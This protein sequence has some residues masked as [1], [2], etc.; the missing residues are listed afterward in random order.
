MLETN[1]YD[2]LTWEEINEAVENNPVALIP[3][4][5]VEDHGKHLPLNTDRFLASKICEGTAEKMGDKVLLLPPVTQ[6]F[7][8]H[9]MEF[10]GGITIGWSNF[11]NHLV[12]ITS[13]LAHHGFQKILMVNGHGS[14]RP[15]VEIAARLTVVQNS[16]VHC[17]MLSWWDIE[18]VQETFSEVIESELCSHGAECETSLY[19]ALNPEGVKMERAEKDMSFP[20]SDYIYP[21]FYHKEKKGTSVKSMEW[22]STRSRTGVIGDPTKASAEKGEKIYKSAVEGLSKIVTDLRDREFPKREDKHRNR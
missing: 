8:P 4:G 3:V 5:S 12:D 18:E 6:G 15:L 2:E 7:L 9:H 13:S 21:G 20:E 17:A 16:K 1:I 19:L 10:P 22:W 11:V 14:N